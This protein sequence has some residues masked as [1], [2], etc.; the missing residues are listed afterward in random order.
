MLSGDASFNEVFFSDVR[1]PVNQV[2]GE[3]DGGWSVAITAL[4]HERA[5]LGG[6][7]AVEMTRVFDGIVEAARGRNATDDPL[8]R[9]KIAQ[10]FLE[11]EV[12]RMTSARAQSK[13]GRGEMP[14]PEGS[15]LKLMW[16]NLNQRMA[17]STVEILGPYGQLTEGEFGPLS[18]NYLRS[19]GNSIEA[20]T[21]EILKNT[22]AYR[23][24]GMPKSY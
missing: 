10:A 3:I 6:G 23:V 8:V 24:L 17:Q 2:L 12:Y 19:R 18:Y 15:I 16:S 4:M 22:I 14:G 11:L 9:E 7:M 5:N 13:I 20:G 21:T 1:V